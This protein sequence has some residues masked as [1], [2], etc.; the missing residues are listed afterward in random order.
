MIRQIW[1]TRRAESDRAAEGGVTMFVRHGEDRE[2]WCAG[3]LDAVDDHHGDTMHRDGHAILV[4]YGTPL[5][6]RLRHA[7]S[8][9]GFSDFVSTVEGFRAIKRG[10]A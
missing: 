4:V 9:F 7:L 5:S 10:T 1:N 8:A 2:S 3:I 6:G